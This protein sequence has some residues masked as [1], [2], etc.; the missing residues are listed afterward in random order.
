MP[1]KNIK[2][3]GGHPLLAY[4]IA[5]CQLSKYIDK[6]FVSTDDLEIANVAEEYGAIVPFLRPQALA[7][8]SATDNDVLRH[9]FEHG[10]VSDDHLV[11]IR[12]TTPLRDPSVLDAAIES[13]FCDPAVE[14]TSMRSMHELPESPYK[15]F[16]IEGGYCY[17]FI[18]T[19]DLWGRRDYTNFPRQLLP[20]AYH[21]NG[22][23][24]V[25]KKEFVLNGTT[26]GSKIV[27]YITDLVVEIDT[28]EQ[29][30][31]LGD[32]IKVNSHRLL[33]HLNEKHRD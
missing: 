32:H 33:E 22:Y 10:L 24:D 8:D 28:I 26:F 18:E 31:F 20:K 25:V 17:G 9:F 2:L 16:K 21:P 1:R 5:A 15:Y 11:Y 13:F 4:S 7:S 29:F 30:Q 12:P 14:K 27:P 6:I 19:V 3:L 23:I